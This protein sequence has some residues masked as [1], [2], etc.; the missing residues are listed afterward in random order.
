VPP[1]PRVP[2]PVGKVISRMGLPA[3]PR[4]VSDT[5]DLVR[6]NTPILEDHRPVAESLEWRLAAL[7]WTRA[8]VLPFADQDVPYIVNNSGRLSVNAAVLLFEHLEEVRPQGRITVL[9][10]GAGTGLFARYLID[11]FTA[12]CQEQ[13]RDYHERL[14]YVVSD[15]S[16]RT[17]EHWRERGIFADDGDTVVLRR[18]DAQA[19]DLPA[20]AG[21]DVHAVFCNY[22]LDILPASVV[23]RDAGGLRELHVR[24]R[25]NADAAVLR[26]VTTLE[27]SEIQAFVAT[28]DPEKLAELVPLANLFDFETQFLPASPQVMRFADALGDFAPDLDTFLVNHGALET[29]HRL[30]GLVHP[31][32]F[33]LVNDYGPVRTE[34]MAEQ[35]FPQRFGPT[36]AFGLNFPLLSHALKREGLFIL[37]PTGDA[38]ASVHARLVQRR[39]RQRPAFENRFGADAHSHF[40]A[41]LAEA[42]AHQSAGRQGAALTSYRVALER[43]RRDWTVLGE[44][45]EFVGLAIGDYAAGVELAR[46][47]VEINPWYSPW[48]WNVLGDCLYCQERFA[49]AHEAYLQA[50]RIN[51]RD[52]R[53]GL[54]LAY[55]FS[56]RGD[57]YAALESI[58]RALAHD[59]GGPYRQRLIERQQQILLQIEG[60]RLAA[61]DQ[62]A[63]RA[64][65]LGPDTA[66]ALAPTPPLPRDTQPAAQPSAESD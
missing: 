9:E 27:A 30:A 13:G 1:D 49:E 43:S 10:L 22:V 35:S 34:Q 54:N 46:A 48:L 12:I 36:T 32:G 56:Q 7:H 33:I 66:T 62:L 59:G 55:T 5:L 52:V 19:P 29:L 28:G 24:T 14:T 2:L 42:R 60:R 23:R 39:A 65:R 6:V 16:Q 20:E 26:S 3:T 40:E 45:A 44:C 41:P 51:P 15:F 17:V 31:D 38:E 53:T 18:C 37:E 11:A 47:A 64:R 61:Q 63:R 21:G 58:A 50:S 8:G 25:L 57:C 4:G